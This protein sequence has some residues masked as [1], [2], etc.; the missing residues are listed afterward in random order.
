MSESSNDNKSEDAGKKSASSKVR[1]N[2]QRNK[3]ALLDAALALFSTKGVDV[4][5]RAIA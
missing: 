4:P 1:A 5:V 3:D 2:A